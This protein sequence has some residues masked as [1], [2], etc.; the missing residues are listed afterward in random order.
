VIKNNWKIIGNLGKD[1]QTA[2][3]GSGKAVANLSVAV[4]EGRKDSDGV[5]HETTQ[6]VKVE[7]WGTVYKYA[8]RLRKGQ[9]V[10]IEGRLRVDSFTY[11]GKERQGIT[12]VARSILLLAPSENSEI[13]GV[14]TDPEMGTAGDEDDRS[15]DI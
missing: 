8:S 1:A 3:T 7:C 11:E 15:H 9:S 5:W 4:N 14:S 13:E 6:W 2:V 10:L 12:N